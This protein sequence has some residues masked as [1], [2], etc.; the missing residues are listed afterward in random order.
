MKNLLEIFDLYGTKFNW[1]YEYK[2]KYYTFHGGIF[3]ILS[4]ILSIAVLIIFGMDD[5]KRIHPIT[6]ISNIPPLGD[7]SIKFGKQKLYLP[8]RIM[9]YDDNFINHIGILYPRIYYFTN[10]YNN[11]T[12]LMETYYKLLNYSLC[13][14]TSM[15]NLSLGKDFLLNSNLNQLFCIDMDDL[16]MGGSWNSKFINYLRL[17]L[18]LCKEGINY[19]ENNNNCTKREYLTSL[20]GDNNNWF[21]ELLYPTVQFLPE[22]KEIPIFV[23]YNSY[24]YGLSTYTSKID[25]IYFQEHIFKDDQ[26]WIFDNPL[27]NKSYWGVSSI[28]TDY[29]YSSKRDIFR[30]GSTSRLYSFKLYLDYGTVFSTRKYKKIYEIFSEVFPIMKAIS[31]IFAFLSKLVSKLKLNKKLNEFIIEDKNISLNTKLNNN[32]ESPVSNKTLKRSFTHV[33]F[34]NDIKSKQENEKNNKKE[35]FI[36]KQIISNTCRSS[37]KICL[38]EDINKINVNNLKSSFF[39]REISQKYRNT[40]NVSRI[41]LGTFEEIIKE[42]TKFP[43]IYYFFGFIMDKISSKTYNNYLCISKKFNKSFT[44]YSHLIDITTY[45]SLYQQ[46][47][48]LKKFILKSIKSNKMQFTSSKSVRENINHQNFNFYI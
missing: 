3:S 2:P 39:K 22:N 44:F 34:D 19:D 28:K 14:E 15:R 7:K 37:S 27:E 38:K 1:Y 11:Q 47:E 8:W 6:S 21:F 20:Y 25:R 46:F 13:N 24:Y 32:I 12:R 33:K 41:E 4:V 43:L 35:E 36:R 5:F 48:Y 16:D 18:N 9:D 10:R 40:I 42:K 23:L 17:D 31:I 29:Y 45:I 30:Y 26:G